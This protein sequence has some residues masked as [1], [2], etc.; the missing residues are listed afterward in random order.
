MVRVVGLGLIQNEHGVWCV[1]RKVPKRLEEAVAR[2]QG[3]PRARQ[4]WLKRSLRTKDEKRAK[5]LAKPIMMEFDRILA[6]AEALLVE[7]PVRTSLTEAEIKTISD[8]FYAHELGADEE[9]REEGVGTDP[10]FADVHRQLTEAGIEFKSPFEVPQTSSGL[11]DRM[12]HKIEE[13]T[14]IVLPAVKKALARGNVDFI[15]YEVNELLQL[16]GI[17]L[18]PNSSDFRKLALAVMRAEVRALEAI[19]ARHQGE[20][21]ESP[22]LVEPGAAFAASSDGWRLRAAYEG[23]VKVE[24]R[25]KST[26]LE[27]ARGIDRF[28]EL[29]GDLE[30]SQINRRHIREF[31]DAAQLV[32]A[33]RSGKLL[34]AGLPELAEYSRRHPDEPRLKAATINKWLNCLGAV[35]NWSRKNGLI[36][37]EVPWSDPVSGMRLTEAKSN[38]QPWEVEELRLLF[39][40]PV[41]L[42]GERPIG[43]KGEAAFW[44][45]LL[46]LFSGARLSELAPL[47]VDDLKVDAASGV[48]F[49]TI[50]EDEEAGRG[51]KTEQ[52]V[53][54]VP[55]HP[56]LVRIGLVDFVHRV[57]A[58]GGAS[59]RLFPLLTP[60][61]KGGFGEA[62]SKWFGRY[63][64]T[65]GVE[66]PSSVFHSFRHGFKD[67]LRAAGVQEDVNDA[68]TGHSGGNAVARGYGW[69]DMV[70][71]FGFPTLYAA[72]EKVTYPGL[73]LTH[74]HWTAAQIPIKG[75]DRSSARNKK[76]LRAR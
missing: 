51:V 54:A 65:L 23:W 20:P 10:I 73:D 47:T 36:P 27:F 64:R 8:Y 75:P 24:P 57:R 55:V 16:F 1:R 58:C 15:R 69:R 40:S 53:R 76:P 52:S 5:I 26:Q 50:I 44:L 13:D 56:E 70:R 30:V 19:H 6:Q 3:A 68:L 71:R 62:F 72:V 43:G 9:L 37:D 7:R 61:P 60:G 59:A 46:A 34:K 17:N 49:M 14:S 45:P 48:R 4:P 18:D 29:H 38:R 67:A 39:G 42:G 31:R 2:V 28:I 35:L 74:I 25:K 33:R 32:P 66:N 41:Y 21:V 11:S 12:M 22:K 63:K